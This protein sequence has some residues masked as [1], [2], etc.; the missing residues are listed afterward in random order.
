MEYSDAPPHVTGR[1]FSALSSAKDHGTPQAFAAKEK[2]CKIDENKYINEKNILYICT[3]KQLSQCL[4][5]LL[6]SL[7]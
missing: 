6:E 3:R 2:Y 5:L 7:K 4:R 1:L